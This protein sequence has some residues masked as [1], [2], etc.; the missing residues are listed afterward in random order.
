[1]NARGTVA[2]AV[3]ETLCKDCA[4]KGGSPEFS[5]PDSWIQDIQS[6]G[7][8]R[9]NRCPACRQTHSR[10]AASMAV[11]YL[12]L[13]VI[14][15]V[16]DPQWPTGPLGGLGPLPIEHIRVERTSDLGEQTVALEDR[17]VLELLDGLSDQSGKRVAVVVAGTGTG[18]STF[19]PYR[20]LHP[21]AGAA[22]RLADHGPIVVTEPRI[23]AAK[24]TAAW[25][26]SAF[27]GTHLGM[28]SEIGYRA[29]G[30][31]RFDSATRLLYVTDGSLINWIRD[32]KLGS[33]GAIMID[34]AHERS[35]NIDIILGLLREALPRNPRLRVLIASATMDGDFF[36]AY[37]GGPDRVFR[38]EVPT[39]KTW[40]YG[41]PLWPNE[42]VNL[43]HPDWAR[44]GPNGEDLRN[45]TEDF[46]KLRFDSTIEIQSWRQQMAVR[47]ADQ[48]VRILRGTSAG[49]ILA[50]LP[51]R[52]TIEKAIAKLNRETAG[53][54]QQPDIF[55]LLSTTS[56]EV[57]E[58]ACRIRK[59]GAK[60]RVV[61]ATNIAETSVTIKGITF[62]VDSGLIHQKRWDPE[63][64]SGPVPAIPHSKDGVRQRWG[65]VGRDAPGWV[66]PLYSRAQFE[67][68]D[69][70]TAPESCREDLEQFVLSALASGIA[71]PQQFLWPMA[72]ER[73][74]EALEEASRRSVFG[75]ELARASRAL[76]DRGAI[77]ADGYLT[78]LG[79]EIERANCEASEAIA[80]IL[81]D[82]MGCAIEVLTA[83][84]ALTGRPLVGDLLKFEKKWPAALRYAVQQRHLSLMAG[85]IDDLDLLLKVV[86][87]WQA[88]RHDARWGEPKEQRRGRFS[89]HHLLAHDRLRSINATVAEKLGPLVLG[90]KSKILRDADPRLADRVRGVMASALPDRVWI[91]SANGWKPEGA[92]E[93]TREVVVPDRPWVNGLNR[94]IA[95]QRKSLPDG[96]VL[97][98]HLVAAPAD[99]P[100]I[101]SLQDLEQAFWRL[102]LGNADHPER[103]LSAGLAEHWLGQSP[104]MLGAHVRVWNDGVSMSAECVVKPAPDLAFLLSQEP[105]VQDVE[106]EALSGEEDDTTEGSGDL[107]S[108]LRD[109]PVLTNDAE[110][111]QYL[112]SDD[113]EGSGAEDDTPIDSWLTAADKEDIESDDAPSGLALGADGWPAGLRLAARRGTL[114]PGQHLCRVVGFC[115]VASDRAAIMEPIS[116]TVANIGVGDVVDADLS[117][118]S[119]AWGNTRHGVFVDRESGATIVVDGGDGSPRGRAMAS[120][121]LYDRECLDRMV[122]RGGSRQVTIINENRDIGVFEG[123]LLP[124]L[125]R[126]LLDFAHRQG[127]AGIPARVVGSHNG[128]TRVELDG[129]VPLPLVGCRLSVKDAR[130]SDAGIPAI[131]G[132]PLAL[133]Q[134]EIDKGGRSKTFNDNAMADAARHGKG[135]TWVEDKQCLQVNSPPLPWATYAKVAEQVT[136]PTNRR[137]L[138]N[139]WV[140]GHRFFVRRVTSRLDTSAYGRPQR[141]TVRSATADGLLVRL[142]TGAEVY[143]RKDQ[144]PIEGRT[145]PRH[146][147]GRGDAVD[148]VLQA[149]EGDETV[150]LLADAR[151]AGEAIEG[152]IVWGVVSGT[153]PFG[154]FVFTEW[155]TG[156]IH[157]TQISSEGLAEDHLDMA[158]PRGMPIRVR[159]ARSQE[160]KMD[161]GLVEAV[162]RDGSVVRGCISNTTDGNAASLAGAEGSSWDCIATWGLAFGIEPASAWAAVAG[163]EVESDDRVSLAGGVRLLSHLDAAR[164]AARLVKSMAEIERL[165][166][167]MGVVQ[168]EELSMSLYSM[169]RELSC[170]M[171]PQNT[172]EWL[173]E[174]QKHIDRAVGQLDD[175]LKRIERA[176]REQ[177]ALVTDLRESLALLDQL[178]GAGVDLRNLAGLKSP[179]TRLGGPGLRDTT[180]SRTPVS[181]PMSAGTGSSGESLVV[182]LSG[183]GDFK[184]IYYGHVQ[185]D[186]NELRGADPKDGRERFKGTNLRIW[187]ERGRVL[188]VRLD[189]T[190]ECSIDGIL[191]E[192]KAPTVVQPGQYSLRIAGFVLQLGISTGDA[193]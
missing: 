7:G 4:R 122:S 168:T 183:P 86:S 80:L 23:L 165:L 161:L 117:E 11:P 109:I 191:L 92:D 169:V 190:P 12:D 139:L 8:S 147:Y 106:D 158:F 186:S 6:R 96:R 111:E 70:H 127:T 71:D 63:T 157:R 136:A 20:L 88:A 27:H 37:F 163:L 10:D 89:R 30:E 74:Q 82:R 24:R 13:D 90:R 40:G 56:K 83:V 182:S 75:R 87:G 112:E 155:G 159:I 148:I 149:T 142:G 58:A 31:S 129:A 66:F 60:R 124:Q 187:R 179:S 19:L 153:Q 69:A 108:G 156:L 22:I 54:D 49:D 128:W 137:G 78:P 68:F 25:V 144:L 50:F 33:Y 141:A 98:D 42:E 120:L 143:L 192:P 140:D 170:N 172:A 17:H 41:E 72:F 189:G 93:W 57:Q 36:E 73:D 79:K 85:C 21:P 94:V 84:T 67:A 28:G 1:M 101:A 151:S 52:E 184:R 118:V 97:L 29:A 55:P 110:E 138:F 173:A 26:A 166:Q 114:P 134:V 2:H 105:V 65:R 51:G 43:E 130:L 176:H 115:G 39:A 177:E 35:R 76:I 126:Q 164:A 95:W 154:V 162:Q 77:D 125:A 121:D 53:D 171:N 131:P 15:R 100:R 99:V 175:R 135:V 133:L 64:A 81:G 5:Y 146:V 102:V 132:T 46:A 188:A 150:A 34:E 16:A 113:A 119:E 178:D 167:H 45:L 181:P 14:A 32:G 180:Q 193:R 44:T 62:V 152:E 18:K 61:I 103:R 123:T 48:V 104:S 107:A 160:G 116:D 9:S 174:L 3:W 91:R 59:P 47:V 185:I 38:L 145:T